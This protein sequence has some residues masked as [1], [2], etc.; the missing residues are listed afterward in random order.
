MLPLKPPY[1]ILYFINILLSPNICTFWNTETFLHPHP[2][3]STLPNLNFLTSETQKFK[4]DKFLPHALSPTQNEP[5]E[6]KRSSSILILT[7]KLLYTYFWKTLPVGALIW[8]IPIWLIWA[9]IVQPT[10]NHQKSNEEL[11]LRCEKTMTRMFLRG[12]STSGSATGRL[13]DS[14][15]PQTEFKVLRKSS[16]T[17]KVMPR[18]ELVSAF[19]AV[20]TTTTNISNTENVE[21]ETLLH[22]REGLSTFSKNPQSSRQ[23]WFDVE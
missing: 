8:L 3:F 20:A 14:H 1:N 21:Y 13:L 5:N 2:I 11:H 10:S 16:N 4:F 7:M 12:G 23:I 18:H 22:Y 17:S 15:F 9:Q 6:P 19:G